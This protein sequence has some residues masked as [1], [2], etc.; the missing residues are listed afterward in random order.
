MSISPTR[1]DDNLPPNIADLIR[2]AVVDAISENA[3]ASNDSIFTIPQFTKRNPAFPPGSIRH[4]IFHEKP[5]MIRA[6]ALIQHG[7]RLLI[8]SPRFFDWLRDKS[9]R[10]A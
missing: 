10:A 9:R 3:S 6:G 2:Q 1:V 8:D 4:T 7:R 5:E